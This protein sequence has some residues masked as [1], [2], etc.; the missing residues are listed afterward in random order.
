MLSAGVHPSIP[1][2]EFHSV[3]AIKQCVMSGLGITFLPKMAVDKEI[4]QGKLLPLA[5]QGKAFEIVTQMVYHKDKW[6]SPPLCRFIEMTRAA[7]PREAII[8]A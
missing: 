1:I 5:W 3:E 7:M 4:A 2:M 8:T 6:L